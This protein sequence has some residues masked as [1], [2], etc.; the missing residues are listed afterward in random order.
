[1]EYVK[2]GSQLPE[3]IYERF[4]DLGHGDKRVACAAAF[5]WYFTTEPEVTRIYREWARAITE[6]FATIEEPPDTVKA[7][8]EKRALQPAARRKRSRRK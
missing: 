6:G 3:A 8:L 1:M 7:A 2:F 5:L 4:A